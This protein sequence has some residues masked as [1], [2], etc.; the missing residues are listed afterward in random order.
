MTTQVSRSYDTGCL[1]A[2]NK[3]TSVSFGT[4]VSLM[5]CTLPIFF[6]EGKCAVIF[7]C[8]CDLRFVDLNGVLMRCKECHLQKD[9]FSHMMDHKCLCEFHISDFMPSQNKMLSLS[10]ATLPGNLL[11]TCL[12]NRFLRTFVS[13]KKH[14]RVH[15]SLP[16]KSK[17]ST[18]SLHHQ[19][20]R[21][22]SIYR[23][24]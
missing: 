1:E 10:F 19:P 21:L 17:L 18:K 2:H 13:K 24:I 14:V 11:N 4:M 23:F 6:I 15:S 5:V 9:V 8:Q 20:G 7:Y 12:D 22:F 16:G 3:V